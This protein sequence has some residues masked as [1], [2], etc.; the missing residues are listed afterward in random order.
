MKTWS[1]PFALLLLVIAGGTYLRVAHLGAAPFGPDELNHYYVAESIQRGD[2][3]RFP[4]GEIYIRGIDVTRLVGLSVDLFGPSEAAVRLPTAAFGILNLLLFAVILWMMGGPWVSVWGTLL[5]AIY[6]E[7]VVQSRF[8]R[9]YTYQLNFGLVALYTG[10]LALRRA[11]AR[12]APD[13]GMVSRQWLYVGVTIVALLLAAR[14]QV[15]T[16]SVMVGWGVCV[17][18]AGAADLAAR[19]RTAWRTSVPVQLTVIGVVGVI[20]AV[21]LM[22][23]RLADA[24]QA[25]QYVPHWVR[26]SNGV[27]PLEYYYALSEKFPLIVSLSPL[28]FLA[29]VLRKAPLGLYLGVWFA[30]PLVLHSFVF[31]FKGERFVF[32]A[33]PALFAATAITACWGAGALYRFV[34]GSGGKSAPPFRLPRSVAVVAVGTVAVA[35]VLTSPAFNQARKL[36][37]ARAGSDWRAAADIL[38]SAPH[39]GQLPI[40]SSASL[41]TLF[42]WGRVDFMVDKGGLEAAA[43]DADGSEHGIAWRPMGSP[44][45]KSG[46]PLLTTPEAIQRHFSENDAVL[47]A[48]DRSHAANNYLE[49]DL[50]RVLSVEAE[51]L[52]Q[53]RCG[54]LLLYYWPLTSAVEAGSADNIRKTGAAASMAASPIEPQA[55]SLPTAHRSKE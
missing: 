7:A 27:H 54:S 41:T 55:P 26:A 52:C 25:S 51:E 47:V 30:V 37:G 21:L 22:P 24:Y 12:E 17:L 50:V 6:P 35:A 53:R 44:E 39:L 15:V 16:L 28:I 11:G 5:L 23:D 48:F 2:G 43:R 40:G 42:Y 36:V 32:L 4:S 3:P 38:K 18:L 1:L 8:T 13:H 9:F 34:L 20:L 29:L 49:P 45:R 10:W 14:I 19:G 46:R 33:V 31:P